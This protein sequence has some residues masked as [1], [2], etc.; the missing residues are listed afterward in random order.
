MRRKIF[1][2]YSQLPEIFVSLYFISLFLV[3]D[4]YF[5][6]KF[7]KKLPGNQN[8]SV[9]SWNFVYIFIIKI[10]YSWTQKN[11]SRN[12]NNIFPIKIFTNRN[13]IYEI[14]MLR[15]GI[16]IYLWPKYGQIDLWQ[17]YFWNICK[18]YAY[19]KIFAKHW[20]LPYF[21]NTNP[22]PYNTIQKLNVNSL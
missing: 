21:T 19:I 18:L 15:T 8:H 11:I 7:K 12:G 3:L 22:L 20:T 5:F 2:N 14:K 13:T 10:K 17:I 9:I 1:A 4:S 6:F 16:G